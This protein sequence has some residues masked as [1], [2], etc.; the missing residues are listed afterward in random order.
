LAPPFDPSANADYRVAGAALALSGVR[1]PRNTRYVAIS[2]GIE[3]R[4]VSF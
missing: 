3:L 2:L 4:W 1:G